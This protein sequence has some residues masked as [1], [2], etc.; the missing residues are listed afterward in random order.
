[1]ADGDLQL[2][3]RRIRSF[4]DFPVPGVLFRCGRGPRAG[5]GESRGARPPSP[6][7]PGLPLRARDISPLLKDPDSFRASI[8]LLTNH[9]KETHGGKIDY[10]VGKWRGHG[11]VLESQGSPFPRLLPDPSA[12]AV[13][14]GDPRRP[15]RPPAR[16]H[17]P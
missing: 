7:S 6:G 17:A 2:V 11:R 9:L 12:A 16:R 14:W 15:E 4:P 10:I 3:A 5:R 1:M 13:P 8:R